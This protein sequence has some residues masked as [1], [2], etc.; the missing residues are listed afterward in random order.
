VSQLSGSYPPTKG[1]RMDGPENICLVGPRGDAAILADAAEDVR[2][3]V[4]VDSAGDLVGTVRALLVDRREQRV[5]LLALSTRP[6]APASTDL[7]V[8]VD[9]VYRITD[10][11]VWINRTREHVAATP[12]SAVRRMDQRYF[13]AVYAH[14]GF[15]PFWSPGYVYPTYPAYS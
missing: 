13:E 7:L 10:L 11:D 5:R 9:A 14:Y 2:G 8:P 4:V 6:G 1:D 3:R 15:Y 12:R